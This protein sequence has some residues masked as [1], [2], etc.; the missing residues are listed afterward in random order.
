MHITVIGVIPLEKANAKL[1]IG[2][3]SCREP[4]RNHEPENSAMSVVSSGACGSQVTLC[5]RDGSK[6]ED[7]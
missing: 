3:E 6:G 5:A 7:K 4:S 1:D 2:V